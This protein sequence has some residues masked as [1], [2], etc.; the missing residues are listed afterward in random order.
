[1]ANSR[2]SKSPYTR[3]KR[4]MVLGLLSMLLVVWGGPTLVDMLGPWGGAIV[5]GLAVIWLLG[6][7]IGSFLLGCPRCGKSL[8]M[9]GMWSVPWPARTCS[10]CGNDLTVADRS[11]GKA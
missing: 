1:M 3:G 10:R 8:F 4:F 6:G 9:R 11:A 2:I 5:G 7:G